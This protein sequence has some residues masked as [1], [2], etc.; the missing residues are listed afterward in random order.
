MDRE[1]VSSSNIAEV[2][3]E[4]DTE[5][6]EIMFKK[7]GLVYQYY[8]VPAFMHERLMEAPSIGSYFNA[9]I[10]GHFPDARL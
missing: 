6:L 1:P 3:Y 7:S 2:G 5:T 9:E 4:P 8:N 10:R